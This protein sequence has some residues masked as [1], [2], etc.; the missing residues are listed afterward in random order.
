MWVKNKLKR[1][2]DRVVKGDIQLDKALKVVSI[3]QVIL[4]P[5]S[6]VKILRVLRKY[7]GY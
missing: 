1:D 3:K 4:G 2:V 7:D 5:Q 6:L